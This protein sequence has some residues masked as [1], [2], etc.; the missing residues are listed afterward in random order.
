MLFFFSFCIIYHRYLDNYMW[1]S[2][3]IFSCGKSLA[4]GRHNIIRVFFDNMLLFVDLF[5]VIQVEGN[6]SDGLENIEEQRT[7][8][9]VIISLRASIF[10]PS[11]HLSI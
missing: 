2:R 11:E 10:F 4:A 8:L 9:I 7:A 5:Q 3:D 6:P 1:K